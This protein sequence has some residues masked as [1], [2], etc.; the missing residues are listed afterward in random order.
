VPLAHPPGH[1]QVDFGEAIAV[2]GGV[3]QKIHVFFMDIP[4]SDASFMKAYPAETTEAFLDGLVSAF[5]QWD[6]TTTNFGA[7]V[8][9]CLQHSQNYAIGKGDCLAGWKA[10]RCRNGYSYSGAS[11]CRPVSKTCSRAHGESVGS[12]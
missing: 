12:E 9:N 11:R 4:H 6:V 8:A 3:R 5:G 7:S 10:D 1:A 2:I